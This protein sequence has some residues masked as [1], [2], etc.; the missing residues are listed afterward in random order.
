MEITPKSYPKNP[1]FNST[2]TGDAVNYFAVS[3]G[4]VA[5]LEGTAK[6][7]MTVRPGLNFGAIIKAPTE[8]KPTAFTLG[9]MKGYSMPVYDSDEEELYFTVR[10]PF[11]WDGVTNPCFRALVAI[12]GAE[13]I[14]DKFQF[15]FS[16]MNTSATGI[17]TD[18][19]IDATNEITVL[20]DRA[21]Q[22]SA[23]VISF[24]FDLDA[25]SAL[26]P[27]RSNIIQG[28]NLSGRLRRISATEHE[29]T[30]EIIVIDWTTNWM[31][32]KIFDLFECE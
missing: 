28:D 8:I 9:T 10:V 30:A 21:V 12:G 19:V 1:T 3:S 24:E 7:M 25:P 23:Y 6:R 15:Q 31:V 22:Y 16:W 13:D 11:R 4:G 27:A 14:G 26:E 18:V 5:T 20:A 29:V 17:L 2:K 32:D